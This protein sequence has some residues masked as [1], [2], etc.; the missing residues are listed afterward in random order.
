MR[1]NRTNKPGCL[2]TACSCY[3]DYVGAWL[4]RVDSLS[5]GRS[6][7]GKVSRLQ[8]DNYGLVSVAEVKQRQMIQA[9]CGY[10]QNDSRSKG[11]HAFKG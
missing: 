11:R 9:G 5:K 10:H 1:R 3:S 2:Y 8:K 4:G 7:T 6:L